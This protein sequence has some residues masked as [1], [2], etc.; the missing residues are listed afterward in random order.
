MLETQIKAAF[1]GGK[2]RIS[3][4]NGM[5][6]F[7][8]AEAVVETVIKFLGGVEEGSAGSG[9]WCSST[10]GFPAG[11]TL[12]QVEAEIQ[13]LLPLSGVELQ[14]VRGFDPLEVGF[15]SFGS[16]TPSDVLKS[17]ALAHYKAAGINDPSSLSVITR[18]K[19]A[20]Y[21]PACPLDSIR[22]SA[23]GQR[24]MNQYKIG[25]Y[26]ELMRTGTVFPPL[27]IGR[28]RIL[29]EGYHRY[30]AAKNIGKLTLP[31]IQL[32]LTPQRRVSYNYENQSG[33]E[34]NR[35]ISLG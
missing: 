31:V 22:R 20:K 1:E 17:W 23:A 12:A 35:K 33:S 21:I 28:T 24:D 16:N 26:S 15:S 29:C 11:V 10:V 19:S 4:Q 25:V 8:R 9:T 32:L 18:S 3:R 2:F 6:D 5:A 27:I 13:R 7:W 34:D 30:V 14:R